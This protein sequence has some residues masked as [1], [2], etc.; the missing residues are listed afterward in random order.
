MTTKMT[1]DHDDTF[2]QTERGALVSAS[3][4]RL[5][6]RGLAVDLT[7]LGFLAFSNSGRREASL[8]DHARH[9]RS[10]SDLPGD[11]NCCCQEGQG[12]RE[13][14]GIF[15]GPK[16]EKVNR[17]WRYFCPVLRCGDRHLGVKVEVSIRQR[18][19]V[20]LIGHPHV[21]VPIMGLRAEGPA[22]LR[23][24]RWA[25]TSADQVARLSQCS[26]QLCRTPLYFDRSSNLHV[27]DIDSV[28]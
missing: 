12:G 19:F 3:Y 4:R 1:I 21:F 24:H 10:S 15:A 13:I 22:G 26:A 16:P 5:R 18:R 27:G 14:K 20:G 6:L 8:R 2:R 11:E 28:S 25:Q 17:G 23:A 7:T 9:P